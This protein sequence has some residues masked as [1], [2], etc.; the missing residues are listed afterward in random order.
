MSRHL[1][2]SPDVEE[3]RGGPAAVRGER[4]SEAYLLP[5]IKVMLEGFPFTIS[6]FHA[7]NGSEYLHACRA[8]MRCSPS[9]RS[10]VMQAHHRSDRLWPRVKND[11][12]D[13][14]AEVDALDPERRGAEA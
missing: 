9:G 5:V 13:L 14:R 11:A 6:G 10:A 3:V 8:S 1:A 12:P 2:P 7:D 4:L